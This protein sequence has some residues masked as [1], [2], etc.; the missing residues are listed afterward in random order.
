M[1]DRHE[2]S[3]AGERQGLH[4][5]HW[6]PGSGKEGSPSGLR[7]STSLPTPCF[8]TPA[9]QNYGTM[10]LCCFKFPGSD[11]GKPHVCFILFFAL[12]TTCHCM[13]LFICFLPAPTLECNSL[14]AKVSCSFLHGMAFICSLKDFY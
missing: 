3:K 5:N 7:K 14:K 8:Q 4:A 2:A 13:Y 12:I 9:L 11:P 10:N 1:E 6:K